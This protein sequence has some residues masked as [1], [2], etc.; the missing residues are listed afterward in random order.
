LC[1]ANIFN[2]EIKS[3][4]KYKNQKLHLGE[5]VITTFKNK[6]GKM[7]MILYPIGRKKYIV[8]KD[9]AFSLN[10]LEIL[11]KKYFTKT[12][13]RYV[14]YKDLLKKKKFTDFIKKNLIHL[15]DLSKIIYDLLHDFIL[16]NETIFTNNDRYLWSLLNKIQQFNIAVNFILC[17]NT[18][19]NLI[20]KK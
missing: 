8:I 18:K 5:V 2:Q 16:K 13:F 9:N 11:N 1:L 14:F 4:K 12:G 20:A 10:K 15:R 6:K 3:L 17:Q 7:N 19:H